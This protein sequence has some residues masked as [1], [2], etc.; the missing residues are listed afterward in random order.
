MARTRNDMLCFGGRMHRPKV[1]TSV[2]CENFMP[3]Q[4]WNEVVIFLHCKCFKFK[5]LRNCKKNI[6]KN[7]GRAIGCCNGLLKDPAMLHIFLFLSIVWWK[8]SITDR[9]L[10]ELSIRAI[11]KKGEKHWK[12]VMFSYTAHLCRKTH[13][14]LFIFSQLSKTGFI[15]P[16]KIKIKVVLA[17][18]V[19]L[20][21]CVRGHV[22]CVL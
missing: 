19:N 22:Y 17:T 5:F 14:D 13:E 4:K 8:G 11:W 3:K 12:M 1:S 15:G 21:C 9:R 16:E 6:F 7:I 10:S 18:F 20:W 2:S